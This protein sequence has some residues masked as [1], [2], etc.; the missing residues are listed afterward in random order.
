M[1][2]F[3]LTGGFR[4]TC[5]SDGRYGPIAVEAAGTTKLT[6]RLPDY[7]KVTVESRNLAL[8]PERSQGADLL[9]VIAHIHRDEALSVACAGGIAEI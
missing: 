2:G 1:S 9:V 3:N 5:S 8:I 6:L 7:I 4:I